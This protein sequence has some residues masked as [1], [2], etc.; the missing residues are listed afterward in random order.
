MGLSDGVARAFPAFS[1]PEVAEAIVKAYHGDSFVPDIPVTDDYSYSYKVT[2]R[3]QWSEL[4]LCGH[5][6]SLDDYSGVSFELDKTPASGVLSVKVYG[7]TDGAEQYTGFSNSQAKV[8]FNR[9]I[10]GPKVK[11][12]TLQYCHT[13]PYTITVRKAFLIRNDG[14]LEKVDVSPF[15]GCDVELVMIQ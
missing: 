11:R 10:L 4:N 6:I 9:S 3:Q 13:Q 2:Y 1:E 12:V 7:E 14:T 15:W 8:M 5:T